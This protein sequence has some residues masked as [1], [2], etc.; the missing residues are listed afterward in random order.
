MERGEGSLRSFWQDA[1]LG[2]ILPKSPE[3]SSKRICLKESPR[4]DRTCDMVAI[5]APV[6]SGK[7]GFGL[8]MGT[9]SPRH[10]LLPS[11]QSPT[12]D[13]HYAA[14]AS[15]KSDSLQKIFYVWLGLRKNQSLW[16]QSHNN[17]AERILDLYVF[18][19]RYWT[20]L[21]DH[22]TFHFPNLNHPP[23]RTALVDTF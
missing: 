9:L 2:W 19:F 1:K 4:D 21:A 5:R 11:L 8:V 18:S 12:A 22:Y 10:G 15:H 13:N 7:A 14:P 20:C 17:T 6:F 23:C 3:S 16:I